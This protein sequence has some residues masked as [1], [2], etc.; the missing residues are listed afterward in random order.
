MKEFFGYARTLNTILILVSISLLSFFAFPSK[1]NNYNRAL[2]DVKFLMDIHPSDYKETF[3]ELNVNK[4]LT[5]NLLSYIHQTYPFLITFSK[6]KVKS[7]IISNYPTS[8]T[9]LTINDLFDNSKYND[10]LQIAYPSNHSI[11][12]T[13]NK[14]LGRNGYQYGSCLPD[15]YVEMEYIECDPVTENFT[16]LNANAFNSSKKSARIINK[17]T[18]DIND[19]Y[20]FNIRVVKND[21][22]EIRIYGTKLTSKTPIIGTYSFKS[23]L[24][25]AYFN[26]NLIYEVTGG[27]NPLLH[28]IN[29]TTTNYYNDRLKLIN[30][31]NQ[32][33]LGNDSI[34]INERNKRL[35]E[36]KKLQSS[37]FLLHPYLEGISSIYQEIKDMTIIESYK[38]LSGK[39]DEQQQSID[40]AGQKIST[41]FILLL[42]PIV[43]LT[44]LTALLS[45]VSM[46][47][48][49]MEIKCYDT[50]D[51]LY[52]WFCLWQDK[53]SILI[54]YSTINVLPFI[55][56]ITLILQPSKNGGIDFMI[57]CTLFPIVMTISFLTIRKIKTIRNTINLIITNTSSL[58]N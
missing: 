19:N 34:D 8:I 52:P 41:Q 33:I 17:N 54:S 5:D 6:F 14:I 42:S 38:Y 39:V 15:E 20:Y 9:N 1:S 30:E 16:L 7:V 56:F 58:N 37:L 26:N 18:L 12:D 27:S 4:I 55:C 53:S 21:T 49:S 32:N 28:F 25:Y 50:N 31:I 22:K 2:A 47:E 46:I 40:L 36:V 10:I 13:L 11:E 57:N 43:L 29:V 44:L 45:S 23:W 35:A 3:V 51:L 48:K 24:M